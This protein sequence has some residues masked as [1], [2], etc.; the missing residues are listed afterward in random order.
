MQSHRQD[1]DRGHD[2][3]DEVEGDHGDGPLVPALEHRRVAELYQQDV[4]HAHGT[5][6]KGLYCD[7]KTEKYRNSQITGNI[8]VSRVVSGEC[9]PDL[10]MQDMRM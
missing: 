8:P 6:E 10:I 3:G 1:E 4:D 9:W 7:W 2:D 5:E